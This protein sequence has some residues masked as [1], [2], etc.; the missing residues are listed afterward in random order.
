MVFGSEERRE[1]MEKQRRK[2]E[3]RTEVGERNF[4]GGLKY[5][6]IYIFFLEYCY[7][8]ILSLELYYSTI[9][10]NFAIVGFTIF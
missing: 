7:S 3:K 1:Q 2:R 9:A 10:K 8:T 6:Y 4:G 5:I